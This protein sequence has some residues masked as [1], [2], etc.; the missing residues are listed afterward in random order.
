MPLKKP[1]VEPRWM[2][3]GND[4]YPL[5]KIL[6]FWALY[7]V[8]FYVVTELWKYFDLPWLM[9]KDSESR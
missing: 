3:R 6:F 8:V 4:Y 5:A 1:K 2:L 7:C 9:H